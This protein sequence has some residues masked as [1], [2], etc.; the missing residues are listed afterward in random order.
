[1][2]K[3]KIPK[4]S[5]IV[6]VYNVEE[7]L[8]EC[9]DSIINQTLKEIEIVCVD[10]GSKDRSAQILDKYASE[11]SR[12]KVVHKENGG[13]GSAVN[14][15]ISHAS[16]EY[17]GIIEP[18]DYI[19]RN[20]FECLYTTAENNHLDV[21][22]SNLKRFYGDKD[23]RI[24]EE[25]PLSNDKSVYDHII[26]PFEEPSILNLTMNIVTGIY[27]TAFI[28]DNDI[29]L[30][31]TPGASFQDN[32]FWIQ[33]M[34]LAETIY[35]L[36]EYFYAARRDNP[37]SSVKNTEKALCVIEEFKYIDS[38][39]F[40]HP[41]IRKRF[42][43]NYVLIKFI[44]YMGIYN[45]SST[46]QKIVFLFEAGN[47]LEKHM[48]S[49]EINKALYNTAQW[50]KINQ[51]IADPVQFFINDLSNEGKTADRRLLETYEKI[52]EA[53]NKLSCLTSA[54]SKLYE[55]S[56]DCVFGETDAASN[57]KISVI[58]PAFN[59]ESY[60]G[61]CL[62]SILDQTIK[63]IEVLCIDDGSTDNTFSV[64]L[65]YV[66]KDRRV[67]ALAQ[68]NSGSG[69]ARNQALDMAAGEYVVFMDADDWYPNSSILEKL[70]N[71]AVEKDVKICGGSIAQ[72]QED[73]KTL[74]PPFD[75]H[76][77]SEEGY[78]NYEDYQMHYGYTR[79]IYKTEFLKENK[80]CFPDY[81]RFQDP[82][83]FVKAMSAAKRFYVIPDVTYCYRKGHKRVEWSPKQCSD[84]LYAFCDIVTIASE[85]NYLLLYED[86][87][88]RITDEYFSRYVRY[89]VH[90]EPM[91][92]KAFSKL[93]LSLSDEK[94][95][96]IMSKL[97][98][99]ISCKFVIP[100]KKQEEEMNGRD[101][102][103]S[104]ANNLAERA[105]FEVDSIRDSWTYKIGRFFTYIPR[106][107]RHLLR[108]EIGM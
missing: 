75:Y 70:Y 29:L 82:V 61:Q 1:M 49:G 2:N 39:L 10:D 99:Y 103:L 7:Y 69:A 21:V 26:V 97:F 8:H 102:R 20:M 48:E 76:V 104:I 81:L 108:P 58:V 86:V 19:E 92:V 67:K 62:D 63:E 43:Y 33:T 28:K 57:I 25:V 44:G 37:N 72:Y 77:F 5:V 6:P 13:Y 89:L 35:F 79:Y 40:K 38:F 68:V 15:G 3:T 64:L 94:C 95:E 78:I 73:G 101:V 47:E 41:Q 34:T 80:V 42:I 22:K 53:Q 52:A 51:I 36:D 87:M 59:V 100:L 17:I 106:K 55:E 46:R 90:N 9:M 4:V 56:L 30:N 18:D 54:Y 45:R 84:L 11:D 91:V 60:V 16:G 14:C 24:F 98:Y 107:I 27:R 74:I 83:F 32:G 93:L 31:E 65:E 50:E 23:S 85:D 12:I 88:N 96:T 66:K 105:R 71:T